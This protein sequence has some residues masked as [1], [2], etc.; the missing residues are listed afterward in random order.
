V[1]A[2]VVGA[3]AVTDQQQSLPFSLVRPK[4]FIAFPFA[5]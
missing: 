1:R 2:R 3:D 5:Q 4:D